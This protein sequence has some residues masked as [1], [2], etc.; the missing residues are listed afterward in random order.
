M[1]PFQMRILRN[2]EKRVFYNSSSQEPRHCTRNYNIYIKVL[3][4]SEDSKIV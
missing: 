3:I 1:H 2:H 4:D